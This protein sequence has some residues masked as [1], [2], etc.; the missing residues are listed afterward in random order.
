MA[1]RQEL[2]LA[3]ELISEKQYEK[4]RL[5]LRKVKDD[6]TAQK[7]LEKL[8]ELDPVQEVLAADGK[9]VE[10]WQYTALEVRRSYGIQYKVSGISKPEWKDQPIYYVLNHLGREGWELCAFES[11]NEF[12]TYILKKPGLGSLDKAEVW[13]Q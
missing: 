9:P 6:P 11:L 12:S 2:E 7:W 13:D 3:R 10:P 1:Q 8:D 4:A 5:L